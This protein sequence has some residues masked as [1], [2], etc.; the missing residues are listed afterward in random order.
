MF[1]AVTVHK[2]DVDDWLP[3]E[4]LS[5]G[6][7]TA[8]NAVDYQA[9]DYFG[10][11]AIGVKDSGVGM[12]TEN[13]SMLFQE[14]VQF[15]ANQLQ[16]G[17]GSGLGLWVSKGFAKRHNG[18]IRAES[19]GIGLGSTFTLELPCYLPHCLASAAVRIDTSVPLDLSGGESNS[20]TDYIPLTVMSGSRDSG[21]AEH[22]S[23]RAASS[24][25]TSDQ[26][27]AIANVEEAPGKDDEVFVSLDMLATKQ[28]EP[29][30]HDIHTS[31]VFK[32][33][34]SSDR[35]VTSVIFILF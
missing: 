31:E 12:T 22:G 24:L 35:S 8:P 1:D 34:L 3:N 23:V 27:D 5:V 18:D 32:V 15:N 25:A 33:S 26:G 2:A 29:K 28:A 14:G 19:E 17:K 30:S 4:E 20:G 6:S 9:L 21:D 11:I 16:D 7:T 13:L 10:T